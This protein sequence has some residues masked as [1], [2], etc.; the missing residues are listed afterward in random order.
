MTSRAPAY[1]S[2]L[3]PGRDGFFQLVRAEFTKLRSV[4]RWLIVLAAAGVV[5]IALSLLASNSGPGNNQAD[6]ALTGPG[7]G[8][9]T[10]R[11]R[12]VHQPLTGDGE[13]IARVV[14]LKGKGPT[15]P[16]DGPATVSWAKAGVLIKDDTKPGSPYAALM[17]THGHGVR[18][19]WDFTE[20]QA[21]SGSAAAGRWLKLVRKG[22]TL[23]GYESA[24]GTSWQRVGEAK[25]TGLPRTAQIGLF[26]ASPDRYSLNRAFGTV[27]EGTGPSL[28]TGVFDQVKLNGST[29]PDSSW[30]GRLVGQLPTPPAPVGQDERK[31]G[32]EQAAEQQMKDLEGSDS[33]SGGRI[34][35]T[36]S[37]DIAPDTFG[38]GDNLG[39]SLAGSWVAL[40]AFA[41]LGA[42]FVT[43]EYKRGMIR[44]TLTASPR[45]GR[46][47]L[48][49][50][51]VIGGVSFAVALP[52]TAAGF[53]W[54][55]AR[56]RDSGWVPP[57]YQHFSLNEGAGLRAV[58][59]TAALL[60][61]V[62]VLAM[63][64]GALL[65]RSAGAVTGV[66]VLMLLPL[67]LGSALPLDLIQ[68]IFRLTPA[69]AFSVQQGTPHYEQLERPCMP[70][71]S[72]YPLPTYGGL[73]VL[74]AWTAI[75][76]ALAVWRLRRKDA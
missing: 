43:S 37:G 1:R 14:S 62:A 41:A 23:T 36:G 46:V 76:L 21:G 49:K 18:L 15:G 6:A 61:L 12:Y 56:M 38:G 28:A 19:Q 53:S 66:I 8:A 69:A 35:V 34:T 24:D 54:A 26:V 9:V 59:G 57:V 31:E 50:A 63:A 20:D 33:R 22:S 16:D 29:P 45:R 25:V 44:T 4:R 30:S 51:L 64:A 47:L 75:V 55:Q 10:D 13:I 42:L 52:A 74:A 11:F 67:I 17:A 60:A 3:P 39:Q 68:W 71:N 7:G 70:E 58:L 5:S 48:A 73:G 27:S 32:D 72:C 65:R 2:S 40:M